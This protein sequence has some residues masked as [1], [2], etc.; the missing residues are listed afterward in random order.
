M[1]TVI[2]SALVLCSA[3]HANVIVNGSFESMQHDAP[4]RYDIGTLTDWTASGGFML[5]E[6]GIN[7]ISNIEA[8]SGTQYV[9]MGHSGQTGDTLAQTFAT[10]AGQS[11]EVSFW[12]RAIQGLALQS[13]TA[14]VV[15]DATQGTLG[16]VVAV[17]PE[18][19]HGW[20]RHAFVF[21]A[22]G[23][24]ATLTLVHD[25]GAGQSNVVVDSVL[26]VIPAPASIGLLGLGLLAA[27]R[28]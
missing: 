14:G 17:V 20:T 24:A 11:Y 6:Q 12:I 2:A 21:E 13:V 16:S 5:L 26:I 28:R 4:G 18:T 25:T 3:A 22:T 23:D 10:T 8:H 27:R 7:G 1:K 9:S 15:D 19:P